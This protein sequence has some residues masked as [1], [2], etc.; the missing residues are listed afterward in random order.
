MK[1]PCKVI[2]DMLPLYIDGVCSDESSAMVQ[3]HLADC[4]KCKKHY[5]AMRMIEQN[6]KEDARDMKLENGLKNL[7]SRIDRRMF[8]GIFSAVFAALLV[9]T[10]IGTL[11]TQPLKE[12]GPEDIQVSAAVYSVEELDALR[13]DGD[14]ASVTIRKGENDAGDI[15][16]VQIPE[17]SNAEVS[18]TE[19]VLDEGGYITV[20]NWN[21]AY[22]IRQ[23]SWEWSAEEE[24]TIYVDSIKTSILNNRAEENDISSKNLEMRKISKIIYVADDGS[25]TVMWEEEKPASTP[26]VEGAPLS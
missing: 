8:F 3:A 20:I 23:M 15:I 11:H 12:L 10:A 18:M 21:S 9:F 25:E 24:D 22:H 2:Q 19:N 4:E 1:F 7:K 6:V 26:M 16:T 17:L 14:D 13:V 5:E